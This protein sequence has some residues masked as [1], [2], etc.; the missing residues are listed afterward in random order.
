MATHIKPEVIHSYSFYTNIAAYWAALQTKTIS[1]GSVR[2]DFIR[3][4]QSCGFVLGGLSARWP[5]T[6][7]CN[8]FTAAENARVCRSPFAPGQMLVVRN[9]LDLNQ[10]QRIPLPTN[11]RARILGVGS[12]LQIKRW[13]RLLTAALTLKKRGLDFIIEIAGGGPLREALERQAQDMKIADRI[14]FKGHADNVLSL[15]AYST[16]LA[17]T[18][19][20]EGCPNVVMEAMACGRPVVATD[21]GDIPSLVADGET[22]FVVRRGDDATL[23]ERL[24]TLITNRDLCHQMGDAGRAKAEQ[25]FSLGRFAEQTF[26]AYRAAGWRD[27]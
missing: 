4:K 14:S 2:G 8:S 21:A 5:R 16:L 10:F 26:A 1:I 11:G 23:V 20:V 7:I 18:S 9:G 17:H 22:G 27:S 25:E 6:Q 3:D 15:L 24:A 19:D 12:L 13:D